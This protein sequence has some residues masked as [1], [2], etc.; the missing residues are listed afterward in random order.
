V[1]LPE[2]APDVGIT[3]EERKRINAQKTVEILHAK[4]KQSAADPVAGSE[5]LLW[6]C[7]NRYV[8]RDLR[9]QKGLTLFFAHANGFPKEIWEPSLQH[10]VKDS[11]GPQID[12]IWT[13]EATQ[14]GDSALINNNNLTGIY[15]WMDNSRDILNFLINYLPSAATSS[16]LSTHLPRLSVEESESR[17]VSGYKD[18]TLAVVGHSFG[19]CT[20]LLAAINY[21][22]LFSSLILVDPVIAQ[23]GLYGAHSKNLQGYVRGAL[24]RREH[25]PT[26]DDALRLFKKAPFFAAW[27]PD[28]LKTYVEHALAPDPKGGFRLKMSGFQEALVFVEA[29]VP[30][31]VWELLD[32]LDER[33]ELRWIMPGNQNAISK[34]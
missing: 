16:V 21:P 5:K 2:P 7:V 22:A 14:H 12:E 26:R 15:D 17:K 8:K 18:R 25:W 10:L 30:Y 27:D 24:Q 28:I 23:P 20:L 32:G 29:R 13:W 3:Q 19:G 31:E 9:E 1:S 34:P 11:S 6:N 4:Q 33:I